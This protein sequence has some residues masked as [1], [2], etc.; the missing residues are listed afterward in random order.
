MPCLSTRPFVLNHLSYCNLNLSYISYPPSFVAQ[1][2]W[3]KTN[4]PLPAKKKAKKKRKLSVG[5]PPKPYPSL[6]LTLSLTLFLTPTLPK[7]PGTC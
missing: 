5:L 1:V 4:E 3:K 2:I 7:E 6:T